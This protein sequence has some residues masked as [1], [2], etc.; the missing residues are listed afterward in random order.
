MKTIDDLMSRARLWVRVVSIDGKI[1]AAVMKCSFAQKVKEGLS[2]ETLEAG[3]VIADIF[4]TDTGF[5]CVSPPNDERGLWGSV[6]GCGEKK[7]REDEV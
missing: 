5:K 2:V 3:G 1:G 4:E 6:E 7:H